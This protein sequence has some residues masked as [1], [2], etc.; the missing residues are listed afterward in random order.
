TAEDVA[1][2]QWEAVRVLEKKD[3]T[4]VKRYFTNP[5]PIRDIDR[6][7]WHDKVNELRSRR[8]SNPQQSFSLRVGRVLTF[9][10]RFALGLFRN[11]K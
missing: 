8:T 11:R 1:R 3:Q 5:T 10:G 7:E 4:Y 2:I 9:P 6:L